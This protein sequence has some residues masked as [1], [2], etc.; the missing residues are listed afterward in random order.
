MKE[1]KSVVE[2]TQVV[3]N[4]HSVKFGITSKGL[5][6]AEVKAYG[7]STTEAL[8]RATAL[9]NSVKVIVNENNSVKE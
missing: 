5:M 2:T 7:S 9:L 6:S 4:V 3:E 1:V 8:K